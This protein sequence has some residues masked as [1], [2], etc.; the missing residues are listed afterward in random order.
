MN[1]LRKNVIFLTSIFFLFPVFSQNAKVIDF[2][3]IASTDIEKNMLE[4]S[5]N[6]FFAQLAEV[7]G[8]SVVD[9]R[10]SS[11]S[12]FY[13][14]NGSIDLSNVTSPLAF[15]AVIKSKNNTINCTL[16][17]FDKNK[18]D[19]RTITKNYDSYYKILMESKSSL[20]S[21]FTNLISF[22]E[23]DFPEL[24]S[25]PNVTHQDISGTWSGEEH[26]DKIIILRGGRGFV[27]YKNGATMNVTVSANGSSIVITQSGKSNASFFPELPREK[28]LEEAPNAS[29][30]VW[31]LFLQNGTTLKGQKTTLINSSGKISSGKVNVQ[32]TKK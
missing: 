5:E 29:P 16:S 2:L 14:A 1:A 15:Y 19:T 6:L 10:S 4:M 12:D 22:K 30:I 17:L 23:N 32:W 9:K 28:A 25:K 21:I 24:S 20:Q 8:I 31:H 11:F 7:Q 18:N 13:I 26:I 3:G 27:I